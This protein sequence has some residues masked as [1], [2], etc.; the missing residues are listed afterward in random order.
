[1]AI[2]PGAPVSPVNGSAHLQKSTFH[3][4]RVRITDR[5]VLR[6]H[7]LLPAIAGAL[8]LCA[9]L[10]AALTPAE[11]ALQSGNYTLAEK[12]TATTRETDPR[13]MEIQLRAMLA[14]GRYREA[15]DLAANNTRRFPTDASVLLA[16]HDA[17]QSVGRT[18]TAKNALSAAMR[19]VPED[20]DPNM[21]T[22][23][24]AA[25]RARA[26]TILGGD[27]KLVLDRVLD[28]AIQQSPDARE[29]Y[30]ALADIALDK[31]DYRLAA[32][33]LREAAK[34][35]PDDA[36]VEFALARS[37]QDEE[38]AAHLE[39]ALKLN[40]HLTA[41]LLFNATRSINTDDFANAALTLDAASKS[42]PTS[43]EIWALR[44]LLASLSGDDRK[45]ADA[46]AK[47]LEPWPQNPEVDFLIGTGLARQYRFEEG[48]AA[49]RSSLKMAPSNFK[50]RF[51]LGS[52]L[53][54][55]GGDEEGWTLIESVKEHDPYDVAAYNLVTLRNAVKDM[56]ILAGPG[57]RLHL[58]E[59]DRITF[60]AQALDLCARARKTFSEKYGITLPFNVTVDILP[61]EQDF[62]IRTF[63]LP[64]GEGFLGVCFGPLITTCSPRGRL[65]RANWQAI[66][67]HEMAHTITLTGTRHRIPRWLSEGISVHE[68]N[69]A[70]RGWGMGMNSKYRKAILDGKFKPV[71]DLDAA[72]REDIDLGYFQSAMVVDYLDQ[73]VGTAGIRGILQALRDN[74]PMKKALESVVGPLD[75]F[76]SDFKAYAQNKAEAYGPKIDWTPLEKADFATYTA[77]PA[78]FLMTHPNRYFAIIEQARA[79]AR[80]RDW[81]GI[82]TLLE[83]VIALE[84]ANREEN[85]PYHLLATAYRELGDP[86]AERTA[87]EKILTL[88]AGTLP[89]ARQLL[90]NART[91]RD[92]TAIAT[93]AKAVLAIDPFNSDALLALGRSRLKAGSVPDA[94][95]AYDALFAGKPLDTPRLRMEL[96]SALIERN[97]PAGHRQLL[98]AL[99]ENPRLLPALELLL[100]TTYPMRTP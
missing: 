61:T 19:T 4:E 89:A 71:T 40:P 84:P 37:F 44:S 99:E 96:A 66:L 6:A 94:I 21:E 15:A 3:A 75:K 14:T 8:C 97:D 55:F 47:A 18:G 57:V 13:A 74:K 38:A 72:F 58:S 33:T 1:M 88:D 93:A 76:E 41:A 100:R 34:R 63:Q 24:G 27:P 45:A 26:I 60:G 7:P 86:A 91:A 28:K 62:A 31:H 42:N 48:I 68:E 20:Y 79:L 64:G 92:D 95:A 46:R 32:K 9:S 52:N 2:Q 56:T 85:N 78:A 17:L 10:P 54:R 5:S 43:P 29:P 69:L 82:K 39:K 30:L 90:E 25:A 87:L 70:A 67:W 22:P 77:D 36:D 65:E 73:R 98:I 83:P 80:T 59:A 12:L 81:Q 11:K 53:L 23:A 16:T 50:T 49:L 35:F 51:E